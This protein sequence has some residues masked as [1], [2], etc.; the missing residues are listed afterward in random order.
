MSRACWQLTRIPE[1]RRSALADFA[2]SH[3][4][5]LHPTWLLSGRILSPQVA[6]QGD[7]PGPSSSGIIRTAVVLCTQVDLEGP[8]RLVL[9]LLALW[10]NL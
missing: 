10:L 3:A 8:S 7:G 9:R 1:T 5:S 2:E 4:D 6:S